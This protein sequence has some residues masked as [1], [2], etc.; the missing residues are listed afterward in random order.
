MPNLHEKAMELHRSAFV[1]DAHCDTLL[2]IVEG[3]HKLGERSEKGQIDLPRLHKGNVSA[4]VF[5]IWTPPGRYADALKYGMEAVDAF[6]KEVDANDDLI[7]ATSGND[8]DIAF[9][10]GAVAGILSLE[11]AEPL[12][13]SIGVLRDFYRL[14]LRLVTLTWNFRNEAADGVKESVTGGGL[15][16]FG[17]DLVEACNELGIVIDVSHLSPAGVEDVLSL[18]R[19]PVIASHSN[20][21]AICDHPRNLTDEQIRGIA[22]T[23]GAVGVTFVPD[24]L[25]KGG[26]GAS[27]TDV[28][29]HIDYMV[30]LVGAEHVMLGSD[31]DGMGEKVPLGLE[32]VG[33]LPA[34]TEGLLERGYTEKEIRSILGENFRRVFGEVTKKEQAKSR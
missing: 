27:I 8:L 14:G 26:Y 4:Q 10:K 34:L 28:L 3:K 24:F 25:R 9:S 16:H 31:F 15:T 2:D 7:L 21:A 13:G 20:A 23:G 22:A 30:N 11:G 32:D 1:S 29:D 18:S 17:R 12:S 33:K 5:A 19:K 6:L